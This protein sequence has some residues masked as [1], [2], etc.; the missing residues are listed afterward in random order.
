MKVWFWRQVWKWR[1]AGEEEFMFGVRM[2]D[3][4]T[5]SGGP[6]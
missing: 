5:N 1:I 3:A 2:L 6:R 4:F